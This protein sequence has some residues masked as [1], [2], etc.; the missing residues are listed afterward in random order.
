MLFRSG[1]PFINASAA[2]LAAGAQVTITL[3]LADPADVPIR[4]STQVLAGTGTR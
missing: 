3:R 2:S 4:Y 1:R